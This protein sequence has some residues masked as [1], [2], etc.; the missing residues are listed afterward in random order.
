MAN[1]RLYVEPPTFT[2]IQFGLLSSLDFA[3]RTPTD[4]HWQMGVNYESICGVAQTTYDD[5]IAVTGAGQGQPVPPSPPKSSN[6]AG[7]VKRGATS[8]TVYTEVDCSAVGFWD[9]AEE[10]VG[11]QITRTEQYQVEQAF[12]TGV[13]GGQVVAYPH[14]QANTQ[15][16]DESSIILQTA[17]TQVSG[18]AVMDVVEG[19]GR[20]EATLGACY[21]GTGILHVPVAL[22]AAMAENMLLVRDGNRYRTPKGHI[23]VLGDGYRGT[24][25]ADAPGAAAPTTTAWVYATGMMFIYRSPVT[26]IRPQSS[27]ID[28]AENTVKAIAERTYVLGWDCCHAAVQISLGGRITGSP[29]SPT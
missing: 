24:G 22:A 10:I 16:L 20:L 8:F 18:G 14:L 19:I 5:C 23:V 1:A 3:L 29:G 28:K 2:S 4:P 17:A 13:A 26:I 27:T 25:P 7:L 15:I 21:D 6:G 12:W 11:E 9:R